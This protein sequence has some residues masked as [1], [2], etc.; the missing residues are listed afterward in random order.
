MQRRIC[1]RRG[2]MERVCGEEYFERGVWRRVCGE[3][4]AGKARDVINTVSE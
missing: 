2:Y 3:E 4:Y 1:I